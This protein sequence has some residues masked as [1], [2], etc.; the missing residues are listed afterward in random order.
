[1]TR[2]P[3]VRINPSIRDKEKY[4]RYKRIPEDAVFVCSYL[5]FMNPIDYGESAFIRRTGGDDELWIAEFDVEI[6]D[7][8]RYIALSNGESFARFNC[9]VVAPSTG[10]IIIACKTLLTHL[11]RSRVGYNFPSDFVKE[12]LIT[13]IEFKCVVQSLKDEL[14]HNAQLAKERETEIVK[15][16]EEL[17]LHPRPDG[18]SPYSWVAT[19][20]THPGHPILIDT[21]SG[22]FGCPYCCRKGGAEELRK[23]YEYRRQKKLNRG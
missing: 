18:R 3:D 15:T 17:G 13:G 5:V 23:F 16:A 12:G 14:D 19:C 8:Y 7:E 4:G 1:M 22:I 20:P 11:F 21:E 10:D 2:F 6:S 9:A